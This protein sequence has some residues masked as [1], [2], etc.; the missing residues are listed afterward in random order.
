MQWLSSLQYNYIQ[1]SQTTIATNN[2][3][4]HGPLKYVTSPKNTHLRVVFLSLIWAWL[5]DVNK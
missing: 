1:H 4:K 3:N 5:P 2:N